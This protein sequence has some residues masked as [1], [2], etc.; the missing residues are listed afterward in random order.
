MIDAI[1]WFGGGIFVLNLILTYV[2]SKMRR[3]GLSRSAAISG[4]VSALVGVLV[5]LY[6][7]PSLSSLISTSLA[8]VMG[9]IAIF[10]I[11]FIIL[12]ALSPNMN[13]GL[14]RHVARYSL[15]VGWLIG[16]GTA[17]LIAFFT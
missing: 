2:L 17:L 3:I 16:Y 13:L 8:L 4:W 1:N 5:L 6:S 7:H 11:L 9:I 15:M 10:A 14:F 12:P